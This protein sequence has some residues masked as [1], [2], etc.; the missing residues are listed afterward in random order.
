[1]GEFGTVRQILCP[2][3]FCR[4]LCVSENMFSS[5]GRQF[6]SVTPRHKLGRCSALVVSRAPRDGHSLV[7]ADRFT[8]RPVL[9]LTRRLVFGTLP[10][11]LALCGPPVPLVSSRQIP[12]CAHLKRPD[13]P[14]ALDLAQRVLGRYV[15]RCGRSGSKGRHIS[16]SV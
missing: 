14:P 7:H 8:R 4:K 12:Y 15:C 13:E 16:E 5:F 10:R 9:S 3:R 1:L 11:V 2:T 6:T